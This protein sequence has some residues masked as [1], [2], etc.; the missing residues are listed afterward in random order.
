MPKNGRSREYSD[1][2]AAVG[3]RLPS[4]HQGGRR[5]RNATALFTGSGSEAMRAF[6]ASTPA[7]TKSPRQSR[8]V[9]SR[10]P[11][12]SAIRGLVQPD[13]VN[14]T[15]RALSAS[16]RS[17]DV[18]RIDKAARCSLSSEIFHSRRTCPN[19]CLKSIV[20]QSV[21]QPMGIC[22]ARIRREEWCAALVAPGH[23]EMGEH[24][25]GLYRR[26]AATGMAAAARASRVGRGRNHS[27]LSRSERGLQRKRDRGGTCLRRKMRSLS[28]GYGITSSHRPSR[29]YES[30]FNT[31][32]WHQDYGNRTTGT[33][34]A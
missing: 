8:A 18:A 32:Q 20:R 13:S 28:E 15:T 29:F 6:N 9:S 12:A 24:A 19:R 4:G 10:T 30:I 21:G 3:C 22:L 7:R 33:G 23:A 31:S 11:N 25:P 17:R 34:G 14:R 1:R 26:P 16:P 2:S 5:Q 27:R